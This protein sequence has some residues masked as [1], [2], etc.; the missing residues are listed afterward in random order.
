MAGM[1]IS[2]G[3]NA[4]DVVLW[5]ALGHVERGAYVDVGANHPVVDSVTHRFV[6]AGWR[7]VDV[8]PVPHFASLLRAARPHGEVVEAVVSDRPER[9]Q[10]LHEVLGTGL[11]TTDDDL[12]G[13]HGRAGHTTRD[14][15]VPV[16]TL[17]EVAELEPASDAHGDTHLLK[18]DVEGDEASVLRSADFTSWRPWVLVV[19]A[20][21][22]MSTRQTHD[23]WEPDLLASGY[24]FCLFDGLSRF[25]VAEEHADLAPALS[26][27]ACPLDTFVRHGEQ[28]LRDEL[29]QQEALVAGHAAEVE[30]LS[31][32]MLSWRESALEA[33]ATSVS[34]HVAAPAAARQTAAERELD[35]MRAT[36]SWRVTAPLRAVRRRSTRPR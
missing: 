10:V 34:G 2:Y 30:L 5:R 20:T 22:P 7:G 28:R 19:E 9:E 12:A 11:S 4:E 16:V 31:G 36:V 27:P 8:E 24:R 1:Q 6:R 21:E 23:A 25:Y 32:A 17:A 13:N 14:I 35:A 18:V 26:Y 15:T 3:Q 29:A 33:W